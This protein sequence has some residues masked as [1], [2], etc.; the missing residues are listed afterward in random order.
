MS[1]LDWIWS[2]GRTITSLGGRCLRARGALVVEHRVHPG[3]DERADD[4]AD[5]SGHEH[6]AHASLDDAAWVADRG[7][8][9]R[10]GAAPGAARGRPRRRSGRARARGATGRRSASAA[11]ADVVAPSR[12][13]RR[14]GGRVIG[15]AVAAEL[16]ERIG[17]IGHRSPFVDLGGRS[18]VLLSPTSPPAEMVPERA[19]PGAYCS[20]GT[21]SVRLRRGNQ[22][23]SSRPFSGRL[24]HSSTGVPTDGRDDPSR[25][26]RAGMDA[27]GAVPLS[28]ALG[29]LSVRRCR[30]RQGAQ[31]L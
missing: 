28:G 9:V 6:L 3:R 22:N 29:V 13:V 17:R 2:D 15:G 20:G 4:A 31:D 10:R 14:L 19:A 1:P 25:P 30:G 5:E 18:V 21:K 23:P 11:D 16:A 24:I 26:H 8:G 12:R 27:P 7:R